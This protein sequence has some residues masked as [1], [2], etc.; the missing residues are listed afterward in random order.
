MSLRHDQEEDD[1]D[2]DCAANERQRHRYNFLYDE[3][4]RNVLLGV[5]A[6]DSSVETGL[7]SNEVRPWT[8]SFFSSSVGDREEATAASEGRFDTGRRR[9]K[10]R[11]PLDLLWSQNGGGLRPKEIPF[12]CRHC[13]E[14]T[15][16][17]IQ[18]YR[19]DYTY[20]NTGQQQQSVRIGDV[21]TEITTTTTTFQCQTDRCRAPMQVA[22]TGDRER[23][24]YATCSSL[25]RHSAPA[26]VNCLQQQTT[27]D[28]HSRA[29]AE[30][31]QTIREA[32]DSHLILPFVVSSAP[33]A[34][35]RKSGAVAVEE[36][37][38]ESADGPSGFCG[39]TAKHFPA[40]GYALDQQT[41]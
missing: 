1:D 38:T 3:K 18:Q 27:G 10:N 14:N 32:L 16:D 19:N 5:D 9:R 12:T 23:K 30:N 17:Y 15:S 25:I 20:A 41:T 13:A 6:A 36:R 21:P 29:T 26:S 22:K 24:A 33:F 35:V 4:I 11:P 40:N 31:C 7:A 8:S 28:D 2:D 37:R 39:K 34:R